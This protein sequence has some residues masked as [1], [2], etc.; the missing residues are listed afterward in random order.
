VVFDVI[1][2]MTGGGP[3]VSTETLSFINWQAFLVTTD[4]GYGGAISVMLVIIALAIAFVY[5]R[6][7]KLGQETA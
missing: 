5:V 4:F 1:Y 7:M 2:I 6:V 3:G